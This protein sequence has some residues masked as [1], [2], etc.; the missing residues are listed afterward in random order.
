[1][2]VETYADL[3]A[4]MNRLYAER[5]YS[6]VYNLLAAEGERFPEEAFTVL[7]MRSC[8]AARMGNND[9]A[10]SLL[11]EADSKGIWYGEQIMRQSP[12]WQ[13]LQ[14]MPAFEEVAALFK[15]REKDAY[16]GPLML[17]EEPAGGCSNDKACPV[18]L[19]LHGNGGNGRESLA[20]WHAVSGMGWLQASLQSSLVRATDS[21]IWDDQDVVL[22]EI[23]THYAEITGKYNVD[24]ERVILAGFSMGGETALRA[25]LSGTV[26]VEGF[27]LLG[28][29]GPTVDEPD[30]FLPLIQEAQAA[31]R[32]LRGYVFLGDND[33]LVIPDAIRKLVGMLNDNGVPCQLEGVPIIRHEYPADF[34]PYIERAIGFIEQ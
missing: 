25:A 14:G 17:V 22:A 7:Y 30:E 1:M 28:P 33:D 16:V 6:G 5:D 24:K 8:M 32:A 11:R 20:G 18:I 21:F 4:E 10:V 29:G 26:P 2:P 27:I 23:A 15:E 31:G 3:N 9:E 19:T 34:A 13:P 12:S